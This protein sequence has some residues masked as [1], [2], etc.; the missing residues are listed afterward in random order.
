MR[1]KRRIKGEAGIALLTIIVFAYLA[2]GL[3]VLAWNPTTSDLSGTSTSTD[4][5]VAD[6]LKRFDIDSTTAGIQKGEDSDSIAFSIKLVSSSYNSSATAHDPPSGITVTTP[7]NAYDGDLG[8]S[9]YFTYD[10]N[11]GI[12]KIITFGTSTGTITSVDLY[13]H[14]QVQAATDDQYSLGWD[15][16]G[17]SETTEWALSSTGRTLDTYVF[18]NLAEPNDGS[19]SWTDVQNFEVLW[20]TQKSGG[21][22]G[23]YVYVYEVWLQVNGYGFDATGMTADDQYEVEFTM[24]EYDYSMMFL[25]TGAAAGTMKFFYKT[26][27]ESTWSSGETHTE[28]TITSGTAY[29]SVS[30]NIG[31]TLTSSSTTTGSV[32]LVVKKNYLATLGATGSTISTIFAANFASGT[33]QPGSGGATPNDRCPSTGGASWNLSEVI[34]DFPHGVLLLIAPVISIYLIIRKKNRNWGDRL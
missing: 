25:A 16:G 12:F 26:T 21:P 22:D 34:P 27:A 10:A 31:F 24:G 28:N 5:S 14:C 20:R 8:T 23:A 19:W 13:V 2:S 33:G 15:V 29:Q 1:D 9:A 3:P 4:N 18:S 7:A 17:V 11:N 6:A 32:K 30:L